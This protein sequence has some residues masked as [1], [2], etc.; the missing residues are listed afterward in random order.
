MGTAG[1]ASCD[2]VDERAADPLLSSSE[3]LGRTCVRGRAGL[4]LG[5]IVTAGAP[6][7]FNFESKVVAAAAVGRSTQQLVSHA[8]ERWPHKPVVGCR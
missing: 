5:L 6:T 1:P 4:V 2:G 7:V 8:I 3:A